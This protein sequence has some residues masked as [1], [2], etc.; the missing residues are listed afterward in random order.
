VPGMIYP[1]SLL[2]STFS[3]GDAVKAITSMPMALQTRDSV[4][5]QTRERYS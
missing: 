2:L 4:H 1:W 5:D 3:R